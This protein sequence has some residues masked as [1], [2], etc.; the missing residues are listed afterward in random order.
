MKSEREKYLALEKTQHENISMLPSVK[1]KANELS[2][3]ILGTK[4]FSGIITYLISKEHN[5]RFG[6]K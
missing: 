2:R 3:K 5:E 4:N 6:E 1:R